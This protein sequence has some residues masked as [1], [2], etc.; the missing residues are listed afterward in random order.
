[1][2]AITSAKRFTNFLIKHIILQY[3]ILIIPILPLFII[4]II[5]G[6]I[7]HTKAKT[8]FVLQYIYFGFRSEVCKFFIHNVMIFNIFL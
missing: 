6:V 4:R 8:P 5:D 1:M 2:A 7:L 3:E